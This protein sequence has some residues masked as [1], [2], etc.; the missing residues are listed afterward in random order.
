MILLDRSI[1]LGDLVTID[2][3]YGEVTRLTVRYVVVRAFD[4]T[5]NLIPNET[6]ITSTVINHSYS[7][8]MVRVDGRVQVGYSSDVPQ[9]LETLRAV[10][11]AHPRVLADPP[12]AVLLRGFG[13]NGIDI[14]YF[15]WIRD[16]EA[17]RGN[18]QSELNLRILEEFRARGIE[19]PYPQRD[20]RIVGAPAG[21]GT[22]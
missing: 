20:V 14:D 5:E 6:V 17:G 16:P 18:L 11:L 10:A 9:V 21:Q 7:D 12:P 2:K 1:K 15:V 3:C 4:G 22:A 19:I 8:R 13:D